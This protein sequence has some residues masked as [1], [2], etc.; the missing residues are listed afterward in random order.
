MWQPTHV[1]PAAGM[2]AW[3]APD[4]RLEPVTRIDPGVE[5]Q[6]LDRTGD[7]AHVLCSNGWSAWVDARLLTEQDR[8]A[9]R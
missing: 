1:V 9:H 3:A 2:A 6:V 4:G 7:W 8:R 5:V